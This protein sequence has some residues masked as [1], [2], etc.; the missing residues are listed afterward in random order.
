M[1]STESK[2]G[3]LVQFIESE[4]EAQI[5]ASTAKGVH[6]AVCGFTANVSTLVEHTGGFRL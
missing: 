2:N 6:P 4:C 1:L 5:R 3:I